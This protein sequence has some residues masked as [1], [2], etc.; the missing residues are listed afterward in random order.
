MYDEVPGIELV[1]GIFLS[2]I[3]YIASTLDDDMTYNQLYL[4]WQEDLSVLKYQ[5]DITQVF[6]E[7]KHRFL[8]TISTLK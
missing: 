5:K 8:I 7:D 1:P 6:L 3:W 4:Q 2:T